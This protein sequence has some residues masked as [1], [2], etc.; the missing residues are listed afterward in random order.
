MFKKTTFL[1]GLCV[2]L[3]LV[4]C[5]R[6]D[7]AG[8]N[9]K[10][11][12]TVSLA[13]QFISLEEEPITKG[14]AT[15]N[16][17]GINVY[18]STDGSD[19]SNVYA[20]GLFDNTEDM[21]ISLLTGYYYKFV[22]T[23]VKNAKSTVYN[24]SD[25]YYY[26]FQNNNNIYS[27]M[28][29]VFVTGGETYLTGLA[30]GDAHIFG[31]GT[32]TDQNFT[33]VPALDRYYGEI[34]DYQPVVGGTVDI[35][36]K[37]A[38]YGVKFVVTGM[39]ENVGNLTITCPGVTSTTSNNGETEPVI[40][41]FNDLFTAWD[42]DQVTLPVNVTYAMNGLEWVGDDSDLS[43]DQDIV[44]KRNY[45]TTITVN[46]TFPKGKVEF[47]LEE[48]LLNENEIDLGIGDNGFIDIN[49]NPN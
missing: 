40:R 34:S 45:L 31:C 49:V 1:F 7:V 41:C 44:F 26:P 10:E 21:S 8:N 38:V 24:S 27:L 30:S 16:V 32:P 17:Y 33:A 47:N 6:E 23:M 46:V 36:L 3:G 29:N 43:W 20:Y 11:Y 4:S 39:A 18:Y 35:E 14:T 42:D 25:V 28:D 15:S 5:N 19:Y 9:K 13:P 22:C 12:V 2:V 37:R 48:T